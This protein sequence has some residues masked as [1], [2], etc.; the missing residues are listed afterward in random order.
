MQWVKSS[1]RMPEKPDAYYCKLNNDGKDVIGFI[2]NW[3]TENPFIEVIEWL[4]ESA[5]SFTLEQAKLIYA[6]GWAHGVELGDMEQAAKDYFKVQ[7]NID[8]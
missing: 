1:E 6:A 7:F 2:G 4:D 3:I 5:P 8:I